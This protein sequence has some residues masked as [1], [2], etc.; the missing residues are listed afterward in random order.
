MIIGFLFGCALHF[1]VVISR[2]QRACIVSGMT[3]RLDR[4]I[5]LDC[6][7]GD[8]LDAVLV[9]A[10]RMDQAHP[11]A[12]FGRDQNRGFVAF[13]AA[14]I[15]FV[16]LHRA[17]QT[18]TVFP[19]HCAANAMCP[20]P[21]SLVGAKPQDTLQISCRDSMAMHADLPYRPKPEP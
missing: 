18:V 2:R 7:L 19:N 10:R 3:I 8:M 17:L 11:P 13:L 20:G 4:S 12:L 15:G 6:I 5:R 21:G 1:D 14:D 9:I 16:D